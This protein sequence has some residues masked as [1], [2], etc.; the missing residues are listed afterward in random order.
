MIVFASDRP[1]GYGGVDLY[2]VK[3]EGGKWTEPRNLGPEINSEGD[4]LFP[5]YNREGFL[6][7]ASDGHIGY[8]GLDIY[9]A[10]DD[11]GR[12]TNPVN[13]GSGINS[14]KDDFGISWDPKTSS[15][16]FN[17]NRNPDTG[18][19]IYYF[20]RRPGI[21]GQ[22][23]NGMNK[24]SIPGSIVRLKDVSGN[25]KVIITDG[26]GNFSEPCKINTGYLLTVDAP[27]Y[28]TYRDTFW[29]KN[30][31]QGRDI[32]LDVYLEVE[33][34][35]EM[36]G[37]TFDA[38]L[39]SLLGETGIRIISGGKVVDQLYTDTD[40]A[41]YRFRLGV[42]QDYSIIFE[43][44]EYIPKVVNLAIG[45]IRGIVVRE[46]MVPMVKG[47]YVLVHGM[48][49]EE[50]DLNR[51]MSRASV[52]IVN[53]E[54]QEII[55]STMSIRDGSF[56][57]A[58]PWDEASDYSI[59][60][61]KEGYFS[62]SSEVIKP[63]S[64]LI[65]MDLD[66]VMR[67]AHFGL[68]HNIK[69]IH[70]AYNQAELD[71]LSKKDLNEIYFFLMQNPNAKLEVRSHTDARGTK[72]YNLELSRR[73]SESVIEYIQTRRPLPDERFISWGFGEEYLLNNCADG[74][75]CSEEEHSANRRTELK[76]VER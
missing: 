46:N 58:I 47:D 49:S 25:E 18:D 34:L 33:Q 68:D 26:A 12:Y 63:D 8:G 74:A 7:F 57:V 60:A 15:G 24:E 56:Y 14:P 10:D 5:S 51:S 28:T 22:V 16:Y 76:L 2:M 9:T 52:A 50:S 73:R 72:Q 44:D 4:E 27:G 19:D 32:N 70:Y 53:N 43:K 30:I 1:G 55:D 11:G 67:E 23:F 66:I 65:E 75:R 71:L 21:T 29:T 31:P 59:I 62:S 39:D 13:M 36:A 37:R 64:G 38:D 61:A 3:R 42:D 40:S 48:I 41:D 6:F 17:S 35:F 69:V 54:T 45:D 20:K